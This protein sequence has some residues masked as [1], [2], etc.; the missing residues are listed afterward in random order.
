MFKLIVAAI[1]LVGMGSAQADSIARASQGSATSISNLGKNVE[2]GVIR[3]VGGTENLIKGTSTVNSQTISDGVSGMIHGSVEVI[4]VAPVK[5]VGETASV[6]FQFVGD[7][8]QFTVD[9]SKQVGELLYEGTKAVF[10]FAMNTVGDSVS[11]VSGQISLSLEDLSKG[12]LSG[13]MLNILL[14]PA[15]SFKALMTPDAVESRRYYKGKN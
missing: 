1:T 3:A 12:D 6:T 8:A 2:A 14:I 7:S 5:F 9:V 11:T 10:N 4:V 13:S 15:E